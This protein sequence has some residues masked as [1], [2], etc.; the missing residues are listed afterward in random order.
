MRLLL[1]THAFLW[2]IGGDPRLSHYARKLIESAENERLVSVASLWEMAIKAS[3]GRLRLNVTFPNMVR[4]H[5]K[6]N[7]MNL[8]QISPEHLEILRSLPFHHKDPFDRIIIAQSRS[9]GIPVLSRDLAFDD[10][11]SVQRIWMKS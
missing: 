8:L 2:F 11:K 3:I 6:G 1:D 5:V 4:D 9:E 7:A 10:Y